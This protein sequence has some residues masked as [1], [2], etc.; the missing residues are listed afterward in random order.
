MVD[1]VGET[2]EMAVEASGGRFKAKKVRIDSGTEF[3]G[4]HRSHNTY[5]RTFGH[6]TLEVVPREHYY[7][8]P[9]KLQSLFNRPT[10]DDLHNTNV[11]TIH[12]KRSTAKTVKAIKEEVV[13]ETVSTKFGWIEGVLV[14]CLLNIWGVILFLRLSWIVGEA[15]IVAAIGIV[16][17]ASVVTVLTTISMSAI[18]TNG[19]VEG[20]GAYFLLSRSLG[21]QFGGSIGMIFSLA[22]AVAVSMYIVGFGETVR[23]ILHENEIQMIDYANDVR[24]VGAITLV[25][26]LGITQAGMAW[27]SKAQNVL[28]VILLVAISNYLVGAMFINKNFYSEDFNDSWELPTANL[29]SR[30]HFIKQINSQGHFNLDARIGL[31]NLWPLFSAGQNFF[32]VFSIFF[33]AATGILAGSNISGDLK[34]PSDAIPKG[35]FSAIGI[36]SVVYILIIVMLGLHTTRWAPGIFGQTLLN[37]TILTDDFTWPGTSC[38]TNEYSSAACD[39]GWNYTI[40]DQ[41]PTK[42]IECRFGLKGD[43]GTMAK[44][45]GYSHLITAGIFAATLSSALACLVSAPKVFQ[46][47]GKDKLMPKIGWFA[48]GFGPSNEPR[49]AYFLTFVISLA[50]ILIGKLD[51]IAPIISNFFLA[52]YG[53]INYACFSASMAN[54][55]GFRPQFKYYNKWFALLAAILCIIIMFIANWWSALVTIVCISALYKWIDYRDVNVNW[56]STG[57]AFTYMKAMHH[58]QKLASVEDH[59]KNYRPQILCLSGEP[60]QRPHLVNLCTQ[61][62]RGTGLCLLGHVCEKRQQVFDNDHQSHLDIAD[63]KA[64]Y[65]PIQAETLGH[66]AV[67]LMS[68]AGIGK[69]RPN[70][71]TLGF[72]HSWKHR[73]VVDHYSYYA[74]VHDAFTLRMGVGILRLPESSDENSLSAMKNAQ[75]SPKK[76]SSP[77]YFNC[78]SAND[79]EKQALT[80]DSAYFNGEI[81]ARTIDVYWLFDDGGLTILIPH[82]LTQRRF[83]SKA[84]LRIFMPGKE[85]RLDQDKLELSRLLTKLRIDAELDVITDLNNSP[86]ETSTSKF[87]ELIKPFKIDASDDVADS[88][89][90]ITEDHLDKFRKKT[91]RQIRINEIMLKNSSKADLIVCTLPIVK[92]KSCPAPLYLAWLETITNGLPPC[93]MLRGNQESV[94]TYAS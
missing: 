33:P 89:H 42:G 11:E 46:A 73:E 26:L 5:S 21:P 16:L 65:T 9:D 54:S 52:S 63:I 2:V 67:S 90:M 72:M 32:T 27:E 38:D 70:I 6:G 83:W 79:E 1:E 47:L 92:Q 68:A 50:F 93:I 51:A 94:L 81:Q 15:G 57:P 48:K 59:I 29:T 66:G 13:E 74:M 88:D 84:K 58:V 82:L 10:M 86:S 62:T 18:C 37:G 31:E 43:Y 91:E 19:Q 36:T 75:T 20:G 23:D 71:L 60:R 22:N 8:E 53:L 39:L 85:D 35:T 30:A 4:E 76:K 14:R 28:L 55:P 78:C 7:R 12:V 41:C 64:I 24:I 87:N 3:D 17:L 40:V 34:D 61:M 80:S 49:R 56:G 77:S 44:I 25:V 69:M 45:S